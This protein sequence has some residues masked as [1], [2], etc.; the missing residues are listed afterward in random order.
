VD[1]NDAERSLGPAPAAQIVAVPARGDAL[2]S[3]GRALLSLDGL[4]LRIDPVSRTLADAG[5]A[6]AAV[7]AG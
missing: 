2:S 5:P 3:L 7:V 4:N 1:R 6:P